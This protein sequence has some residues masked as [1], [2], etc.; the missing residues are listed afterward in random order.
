MCI[1]GGATLT[2]TQML[3]PEKLIS[4]E[5]YRDRAMRDLIWE[6]ELPEDLRQ[7]IIV[8]LGGRDIAA[9]V[10]ATRMFT[11]LC[12]GFGECERMRS[13]AST[14]I[15]LTRRVLCLRYQLRLPSRANSICGV[16]ECPAC[17]E[18]MESSR[19]ARWACIAYLIERHACTADLSNTVREVIRASS[20]P[21]SVKIRLCTPVADTIELCK[22]LESLGVSHIT[23][24]A[25]FPSAK[26]RRH[27]PAKLEHVRELVEALSIPVVSN[28]NVRCQ[29]D[30]AANLAF[31]KAAGLMIGEELLRNP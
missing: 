15:L 9:M 14:H 23:L 7:P 21:V 10:N 19:R 31:T 18:R 12:D 11:N 2:Y 26:H 8:Q 25:R 1:R 6:K 4:D 30:L 27:G 24:H 5:T 20:V 17:T 28:G 22:R 3:V 29:A 16:W 13:R